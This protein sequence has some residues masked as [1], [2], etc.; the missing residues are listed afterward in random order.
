M[1]IRDQLEKMAPAM[2]GSTGIL[3][4]IQFAGQLTDYL[5]DGQLDNH[6]IQSL[7]MGASS[8]L[9]MVIAVVLM[10]YFKLKDQQK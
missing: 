4:A 3:G 7:I 1:G 5:A 6:E 9:Q 8:G 10:A 2:L